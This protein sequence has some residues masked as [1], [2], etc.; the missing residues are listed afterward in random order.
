M[1]MQTERQII[2]LTMSSKSSS[3]LFETTQVPGTFLVSGED[4]STS[5]SLKDTPGDDM[6]EYLMSRRSELF[7]CQKQKHRSQNFQTAAPQ[8]HRR[9]Q[10]QQ[11]RDHKNTAP[12][13]HTHHHI[14]FDCIWHYYYSQPNKKF[15]SQRAAS[16][17]HDR[18]SCWTRG[19][20][21]RT[22]K[23][24]LITLVRGIILFIE[25]RNQL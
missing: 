6:I 4:T 7:Q 13:T 3:L 14:L 21:S 5:T 2:A 8:T 20:Y 19:C 24:L 22:C 10:R 15:E 16:C 17:R 18:Y 12:H 1:C 23:A 9:Q 11:K 25:R